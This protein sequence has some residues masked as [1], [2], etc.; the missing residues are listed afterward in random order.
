MSEPRAAG[1][2]PSARSPGLRLA[3]PPPLP[4]SLPRSWYATLC[5]L[6]GV[7]AHDARAAAAGLPA[8]DSIDLWP[9][10]SGNVTAS[11]RSDVHLSATAYVLGDYKLITGS[12]A[13]AGAACWGGPLYPNASTASGPH[14]GPFGTPCNATG[15]CGAGG[16]LFD[17]AAD[18]SE[19]RDLAAEP[20]HAAVL[21]LLQQKL[22]TANK[23]NFNPSRGH[24][25]QRA[26]DAA[27]ANGGYWGPFID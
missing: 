1:R 18:M 13:G 6:A 12:A 9:Y 20:A 24:F 16:C 19:R 5:A 21:A 25:D 2:P 11:P 27:A 15:A 3:N 14:H 26:C 7:D 23:A 10:L 4:L 22:A 17:V 8:V